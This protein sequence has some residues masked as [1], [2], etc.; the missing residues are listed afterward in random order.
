MSSNVWVSGFKLWG[1]PA[2]NVKFYFSTL[3]N[4]S[5]GSFRLIVGRETL[6]SRCDHCASLCSSPP[7]VYSMHEYRWYRKCPPEGLVLGGLEGRGN[8]PA[9]NWHLDKNAIHSE[10]VVDTSWAWHC[11][12]TKPN[13]HFPPA[14]ASDRNKKY[15]QH[16]TLWSLF[17]FVFVL[18]FSVFLNFFLDFFLLHYITLRRR[19]LITYCKLHTFV[20]YRL[21]LLYTY[22]IYHTTALLH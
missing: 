4:L 20:T 18:L 19:S 6:P 3:L 2:K 10:S 11:F 22:I 1:F 15:F 13:C 8:W 16:F 5:P 7:V 9:M 14:K 21:T 17:C 12:A